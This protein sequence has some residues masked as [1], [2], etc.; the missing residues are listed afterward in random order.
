M[1]LLSKAKE[2]KVENQGKLVK[3]DKQEK[4]ELAVAWLKGEVEL[5]QVTV[6][7]GYNKSSATSAYL[8]LSTGL[9]DAYE[10]GLLTTK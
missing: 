10:L 1:S 7:L 8:Q 9:R 2:I 5:K 4:A 6:V 3:F